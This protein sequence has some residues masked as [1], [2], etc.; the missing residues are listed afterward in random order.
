MA[1]ILALSGCCIMFFGYD[2]SVMSLVNSNPD[3]LRLMGTNHGTDRD[4]A[5]IGGIISVWF[6]G[7]AIGAIMTGSY[8]DRIGRLKT[9]TLGA[10]WAVLGGALQASAFNITWMM[11]ARVIGGIGCGHLNTIIPVWTS[12]VSSPS[13]RGAL[14][15]TQFSLALGG[16]TLVYWMEYGL[17]RNSGA[18]SL[19]W[20]FP[21]AF[22]IVFL[23]LAI[24]GI[25][26]APESPRYLAS[27]GR[28]DE[29]KSVLQQCRDKEDVE[30]ELLEIQKAILL[31]SDSGEQTWSTIFFKKDELHTR[32]RLLLGAGVQVMQ[33]LTG[34]DFIATYAPSMFAL[35]GYDANKSD[36]LAGGNYI[37]YTASLVLSIYLLD[38]VGRRKMM[39]FGSA[40]M[41]VVLFIGGGLTYRV[42][43]ASQESEKTRFGA[44]VAAVL[45]LY[46]F[47][48]G[49]SWLS[50]CWCYPSEIFPL[51]MRS[52]GAACATMGFSIAGGIITII[53]PYLINAVGYWIFFIFGIINLL[54]LIP[55]SLFY[56]ETKNRSLEELD[57]VFMSSSAFQFRAEKEY[58]ERI[59]LQ[60]DEK[61]I[62]P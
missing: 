25:L 22:Q 55:I 36:L 43:N 52:K 5:A 20:R 59:A 30:D 7:F 62:D 2:A 27:V 39:L 32:R 17:V 28:F 51:K 10:V 33:K 56:V 3:Y 12:E 49:C 42:L 44:G 1:Y 57:Y 11:F 18:N 13:Y 60:A 21:V 15:A 53:V 14:V 31:E 45:Y 8:A 19:S 6:L 41:S 4:A 34:I 37:S 35:S 29:A 16:S 9:A 58:Q 40:A 26:F 48:Y 54:M 38:R 23:L 24:V 46:T 47:L 61:D 50:T